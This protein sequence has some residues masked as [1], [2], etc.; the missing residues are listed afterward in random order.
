MKRRTWI[1]VSVL[2][3]LLLL[4]LLVRRDGPTSPPTR[5][6]K[7]LPESTTDA[8]RTLTADE[9]PAAQPETTSPPPAARTT[10]SYR[11]PLK[12]GISG[13]VSDGSGS[14]IER[15]DVEIIPAWVLSYPASFFNTDKVLTDQDGYYI[16]EDLQPGQ[17]L[18]MCGTFRQTMTVVA[19]QMLDQDVHLDGNGLL[20]GQ[21]LDSDGRRL[22]PAIVY[23][24]GRTSRLVCQT[25]ESGQFL[26]KG[27]PAGSYRMWVRMEG[28]VPAERTNLT[29]D[30]GET[31]SDITLV[32][33]AGAMVAGTV[34]DGAGRPLAG[35]YVSTLPDPQRLGTQK[36]VTDDTGAFELDGVVPGKQQLQAWAP[37]SYP[38]LS[39]EVDIRVGTENQVDI[40]FAGGG[41]ID[42]RVG[43]DDGSEL[44]DNVRVYARPATDESG[45][46]HAFSAQVD[47][48][49]AYE[50]VC[51]E[52]GRYRVSARTRGHAYF[53]PDPTV[54]EIAGDETRNVDLVLHRSASVEGR[55]QDPD[56]TAVAN[57][58]LRLRLSGSGSRD[59]FA[60]T[61]SDSRGEFRFVGLAGGKASLDV[62][63]RG[64]VPISRDDLVIEPGKV[65][66]LDLTMDRGVQVSGTIFDARGRP[67][68]GV[69]VFARAFGSSSFRNV[70][71]D[72]TGPDGAYRLYGLQAGKYVI[73]ALTRAPGSSS[74]L[75]S[76]SREIV[77]DDGRTDMQLDLSFDADG[78]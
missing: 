43:V 20:S 52:P 39:P 26:I 73:Y 10:R 8:A 47:G 9:F 14:P 55:L 57:A 2:I 28:Y 72:V 33:K 54:V 59:I 65:L 40:R 49:G 45:R 42:G 66:T 41:R 70:S 67:R 77:I 3:C 12:G 50:F 48:D 18:L 35:V 38:R 7:G 31:K 24:L 23:L 4:I 30:T 51:L 13:H 19:G 78:P 21:V 58:R 60:N 34:R 11:D 6:A 29:F 15:L 63:A 62:S 27:I 1:L 56:G 36:A 61:L 25:N 37:G 46:G 76:I 22:F 17:Y 64:Y 44:P 32:M 16:F 5:S 53:D 69:T 75:R 68:Q 74:G 71:K